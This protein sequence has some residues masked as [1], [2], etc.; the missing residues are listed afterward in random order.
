MRHF[1]VKILSCFISKKNKRQQF[2][3]K[4]DPIER[5]KS[6]I[7]KTR[8]ELGK[9]KFLCDDYERL[10]TYSGSFTYKKAF[11]RGIVNSYTE[12]LENIKKL[13]R[14]LSEEALK[15]LEHILRVFEVSSRYPVMIPQLWLREIYGKVPDEYYNEINLCNEIE[16]VDDYFQYKNYKLPV[17][18]FQASI[19]IYEWNA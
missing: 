19:Y 18:F 2:I 12:H 4:Y 6:L 1:L 14:N 11:E 5:N 3:E 9:C 8:L 10:K 7:K 15:N 17:N 16:R 13:K